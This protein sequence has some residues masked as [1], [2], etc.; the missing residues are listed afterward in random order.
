MELVQNAIWGPALWMILHSSAERILSKQM[1]RLPQEEI[2]IWTGLLSSMKF[3]LPCPQCKKHYT[4]YFNTHP[5]PD[6]SIQSVRQWLYML[7]SQVNER[8]GKANEL[9]IEDIADHYGK[10]FQFTKYYAIIK[11]QMTASLR[12][13]ISS[14][15]DIQRTLRYMEEMMRFYDFF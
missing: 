2:R 8:T 3:S 11:K 7:H 1:K 12:F 4:L 6:F 9:T 5:L 14:R 13:G 15:E 10:P